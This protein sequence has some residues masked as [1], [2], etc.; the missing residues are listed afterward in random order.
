ML[1]IVT[2]LVVSV[3]YIIVNS[4]HKEKMMILE[5]GLDP[6]LFNNT[7]YFY[8][9]LKWGMILA[10]LGAG[11]LAAFIIDT[12]VFDRANGTEALYPS[13]TALGGGGSLILFYLF[14]RRK[15]E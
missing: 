15:E 10:G 9:A 11:F 3:L 2:L 4:K 14:F 6:K 8:D 5:K 7:S 1:F 12:I 13:L